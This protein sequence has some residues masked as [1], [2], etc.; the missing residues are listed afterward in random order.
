[1]SYQTTN[2]LRELLRDLEN[3]VI[4]GVAAASNPQG[5]STVRRTLQ[6]IIREHRHQ[7][8]QLPGGGYVPSDTSITEEHINGVAHGVGRRREQAGPDRVRRRAES[9]GSTGSSRRTSVL[10]RETKRS[11][12]S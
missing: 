4:N 3:T 10:C 8:Q 5:S 12:T 7:R 2:R 1:M 9:A 11:R 6:G